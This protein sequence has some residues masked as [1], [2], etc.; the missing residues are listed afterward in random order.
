MSEELQFE[1]LRFTVKKLEAELAV[2]KSELEEQRKKSVNLAVALRR[3]V[4]KSQPFA[5]TTRKPSNSIVP[6]IAS[7]KDEARS[8]PASS[9]VFDDTLTR[10]ESLWKQLRL[11]YLSLLDELSRTRASLSS[12]DAALRQE[13]ERRLHDI[14][15]LRL[16]ILQKENEILNF[17]TSFD[18][19]MKR[20]VELEDA[21]ANAKSVPAHRGSVST[22]TSVESARSSSPPPQM[23]LQPDIFSRNF[24]QP[25]TSFVSMT[26]VPHQIGSPMQSSMPLYSPVMMSRQV[27]PS[28]IQQHQ[29]VR[30]YPD[31]KNKQ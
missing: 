30:R 14:E 20:S 23:S 3:E 28:P 29:M 24:S 2:T 12:A 19:L 26:R 17:K 10:D 8:S 25:T 22:T 5:Q 13:R 1:S 27:L 6:S 7:I 16:E 11:E 9:D 21:L 31:G 18:A 4:A 15:T